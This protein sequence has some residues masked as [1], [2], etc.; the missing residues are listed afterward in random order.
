M[1]DEQFPPPKTWRKRAQVVLEVTRESL[2]SCR[3]PSDL[4][5]D[6]E[7]SAVQRDFN[8]ILP[9]YWFQQSGRALAQ[10]QQ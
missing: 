4:V 3:N 6:S 1:T 8:S 7:V 10:R 5:P 2:G 9:E